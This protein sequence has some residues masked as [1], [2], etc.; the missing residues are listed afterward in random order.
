MATGWDGILDK[1][2]QILWQGQPVPGFTFQ[3][4]MIPIAGF[5]AIFAGFALFW[6]ILAAR[7]GGI[8]WMFGLIHFAFGVGLVVTTLFGTPWKRRRTWYTLTNRRAFIATDLPLRGRK[9][10]SYPITDRT[11][12]EFDH[13]T[14]GTISF[15]HESAGSEGWHRV[16]F[17]RIAESEQ[18][19]ALL[20]KVQRGAA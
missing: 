15:A 16:G 14:P 7:T 11:V 3:F 6:M 20:R 2:E 8:F 19:Y 4:A 10:R 17:D 13:Q 5:G 1:G 12:L 9:L 18:V